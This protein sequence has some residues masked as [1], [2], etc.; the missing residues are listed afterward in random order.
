MARRKRGALLAS[1]IAILASLAA[2]PTHS[3]ALAQTLDIP[4]RTAHG[5][6]TRMESMGLACS[7]WDTTTG[8][9]RRVYRLTPAGRKALRAAAP[10][11]S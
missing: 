1:E 8:P 9:P 3:Y 4:K 2:R 7:T 11:E 5:I 10:R 6:V